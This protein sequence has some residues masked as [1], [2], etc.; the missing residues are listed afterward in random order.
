[1]EARQRVK[2]QQKRIVAAMFR[3]IHSS[4]VMGED[5]VEKFAATPELQSE[6]GIGSDPLEPS[7][8]WTISPAASGSIL[9]CSAS[10]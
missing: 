6:N 1:M 7:Q 8:I 10:R 4:N 2:E 3:N 9:A 5:G